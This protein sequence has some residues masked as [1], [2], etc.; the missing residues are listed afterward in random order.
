M[1]FLLGGAARCQTVNNNNDLGT[2]RSWSEKWEYY[3]LREWVNGTCPFDSVP[4]MLVSKLF[5]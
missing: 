4:L 5:C 2:R 3:K 1:R